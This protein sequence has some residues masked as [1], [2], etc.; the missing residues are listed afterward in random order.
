MPEDASAPTRALPHLGFV[1]IRNSRS[2]KRPDVRPSLQIFDPLLALLALLP[3]AVFG[4]MYFGKQDDQTKALGCRIGFYPL[5]TALTS[6][7]P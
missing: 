1:S 3:K 5:P 4:L 7:S 2:Q 6:K